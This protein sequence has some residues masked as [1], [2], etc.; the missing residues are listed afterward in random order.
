MA[1]TICAYLNSSYF[2]NNDL[3]IKR[4]GMVDESDEEPGDED[5]SGDEE[6]G[7]GDS[8]SEEEREWAQPVF[9]VPSRWAHPSPA[10]PSYY[11]P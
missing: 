10:H 8:S 7:G 11:V 1:G 6:E 9:A 2:V 5:E 4:H 3:Y